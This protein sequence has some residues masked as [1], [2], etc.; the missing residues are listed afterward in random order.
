MRFSMFNQIQIINYFKFVD[1]SNSTS[2]KSIKFNTFI[3]CFNSTFRICFSINQITKTSQI[4]IDAISNLKN[5]FKLKTFKTKL[6]RF[7]EQK[8]I[9][10][11]DINYINKNI[12]VETSLTNAKKYNSI[13]LSIKRFKSFKSV[14]F[15][16]SFDSTSRFCFSINQDAKTS[17]I[18]FET[19][20]TSLIK[21]KIKTRVSIDSLK[22]RYFVAADVDHNNKNIRVE[23]SLT[24]TKKYNSIKSSIKRFKSFKFA[25]FINLFNSTFR[26]C[27]SINQITKTSQHQHIAIDETSNLE[28][29]QKF[30]FNIFNN[31]FNSIFRICFSVNQDAKISHIALDE[32]LSFI[33][34]RSF[35]FFKFVVFINNKFNSISRVCFSVN[36]VAE[37]SQYQHIEIDKVKSLKSFK[38][39]KLFKSLNFAV[40][41]N[42][43]NSTLRF[44]LSINHDLLISSRIDF[45]R[46]LINQMIYA[47]IIRFSYRF[48]Y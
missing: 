27:F 36:Q 42:S 45:F 31:K 18:A 33:S 13:K 17:H 8:Y 2:I 7:F 39:V 4:A 25:V 10:V 9:V 21:S 37:I 11:V 28:I 12:R 30:K 41:I 16:N 44:S 20:F 23:T 43:F 5:R 19:N 1:Q 46:V 6:F 34:C 22:S 48:L 40:I 38:S 3:S 47:S 35:K 14:V 15:I 29:Q 26:F 32:I 24:D